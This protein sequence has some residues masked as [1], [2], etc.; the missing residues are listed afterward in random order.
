MITPKKLGVLATSLLAMAGLA[1]AAIVNTTPVVYAMPDS[2]QTDF[3]YVFSVAQYDPTVTGFALN[4]VHITLEG[5]ALSGPGTVTC[6]NSDGDG[7]CTG[8]VQ[9]DIVMDLSTNAIAISQVI[10][11]T[12]FNY[13]ID[14]TPVGGC[15]FPEPVNTQS[16][17]IPGDTNTDTDTVW[18]YLN[19]DPGIIALFSGNGNINVDLNAD[20]TVTTTNDSGNA[21][22]DNPLR[23][24]ANITVYYDYVTPD[25]DVPEPGTMALMGTALAGI[26]MFLRRRK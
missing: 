24:I 13:D 5:T 11:L 8:S 16:E 15:T 3:L 12:M 21:S 10:P 23:G 18:F 4:S 26:A 20:G 9:S 1:S 14:C 19:T 7:H 25:T 17:E 6:L 2:E 22:A